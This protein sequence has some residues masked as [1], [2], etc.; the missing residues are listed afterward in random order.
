MKNLLS[1]HSSNLGLRPRVQL[2][3]LKRCPGAEPTARSV[4]QTNTLFMQNHTKRTRPPWST[5]RRPLSSNPILA[6]YG[7]N[8]SFE[9]R[10]WEK[11]NKTETCWIWTAKPHHSGYGNIDTGN[12][13]TMHAHR[14]SWIIHNGIIPDGLDVLHNCPVR[15]N[16]A[17][18]NPAHLWL[19]TDLENARDASNKGMKALG[20]KAFS[21]KLT[22]NDVVLIRLVYAAGGVSY[23]E[24]GR[25]FRVSWVTIR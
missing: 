4:A 12:G 15:D 8:N 17:C 16:R 22:W 10:F 25:R 20:E 9:D 5:R 24:L 19:G 18:V 2:D 6:H 21:H 11:V 7:C 23:G 13:T 3:K 14:A 1:G